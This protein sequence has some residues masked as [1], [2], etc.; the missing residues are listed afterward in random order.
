MNAA[1]VRE[2]AV[3][4]N[5]PDE[6]ILLLDPEPIHTRVVPKLHKSSCDNRTIL[7]AGLLREPQF[8]MSQQWLVAYRTPFSVLSVIQRHPSLLFLKSMHVNRS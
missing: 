5:R 6:H 4:E 3:S 7:A 2:L 8:L 1:P